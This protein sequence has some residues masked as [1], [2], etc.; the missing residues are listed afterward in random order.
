MTKKIQL[1]IETR[2]AAG[3]AQLRKQVRIK[4]QVNV[5]KVEERGPGIDAHTHLNISGRLWLDLADMDFAP[6]RFK[7][8]VDDFGMGDIYVEE[9][10]PISGTLAGGAKSLAAFYEGALTEILKSKPSL[11]RT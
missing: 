2:Q 9:F 10:R 11:L 8:E 4:A 1:P 3:M 7:A 5:D 6:F